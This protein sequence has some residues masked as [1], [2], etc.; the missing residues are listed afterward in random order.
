MQKHPTAATNDGL[1]LI[2][3]RSLSRKVAYCTVP[4]PK[5]VYDLY[6]YLYVDFGSWNTLTGRR[7]LLTGSDM[8][9]EDL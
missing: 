6:E 9:T 1:N 8:H 7:T 2:R 3:S 4:C 5:L